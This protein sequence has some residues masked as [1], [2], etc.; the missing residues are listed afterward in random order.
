MRS[1]ISMTWRDIHIIGLCQSSVMVSIYV[2]QQRMP[3]VEAI[4][5]VKFKYQNKDR[6]STMATTIL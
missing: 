3:E 6:N 5:K 2:I 4:A 1:M